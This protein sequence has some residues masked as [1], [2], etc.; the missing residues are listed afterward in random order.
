MFRGEISKLKQLLEKTVLLRS[1][2]IRARRRNVPWI[3]GTIMDETPT[4]KV[5]RGNEGLVLGERQ[6]GAP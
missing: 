2:K 6:K 5:K 1:K 3:T 4:E